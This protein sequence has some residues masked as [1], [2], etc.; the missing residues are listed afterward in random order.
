MNVIK[1]TGLTL[2]TREEAE[3][4]LADLLENKG[5][6]FGYFDQNNQVI[7]FLPDHAPD[8][9]VTCVQERVT[10]AFR[11]QKASPA[12]TA[13]SSE[14]LHNLGAALMGKGPWAR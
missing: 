9:P 8:K 10:L 6:L 4:V 3:A 1:H 7:V 13:A 11:P 2:D 12:A 5:A 14:F